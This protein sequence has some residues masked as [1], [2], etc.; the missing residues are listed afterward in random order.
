MTSALGSPA[1]DSESEGA[2]YGQIQAKEGWKVHMSSARLKPRK[3]EFLFI[4][5]TTQP[6]GTLVFPSTEQGEE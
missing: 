3:L 4:N 6:P 1:T 5:F 2:M